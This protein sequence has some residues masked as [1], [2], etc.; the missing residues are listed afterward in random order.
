M[1]LA[2]HDTT[3]DSEVPAARDIRW[4][5]SGRDAELLFQSRPR[6]SQ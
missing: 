2:D 4:C 3:L 6:S 1:S 5:L